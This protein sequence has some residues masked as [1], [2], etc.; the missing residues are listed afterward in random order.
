[1]RQHFDEHT[2]NTMRKAEDPL[3][4]AVIAKY[5]P[6]E[7]SSLQEILSK[8]RINEDLQNAKEDQ[9]LR[10]IINQMQEDLSQANPYLLK[11][12]QFF[13]DHASDI[14]LLLGFLSLPYCYAAAKGAEMLVRS[15]RILN[16]PAKRLAETAHFVFDVFHQNAFKPKGN[17]LVVILK[18]RLMHAATRWYI[19]QG[20][21]DADYFGAPVNQEDMA[22]TNLSFSLMV[23]RGLRRMGKLISADEALSYIQYWN[24]V[25]KLMGLRE[26]LLPM[27]NKAAHLLEKNIRKRQFK[28]SEAGVRLTE[29][30]VSYY[31][32][33]AEGT[34]LEG[35]VDQML[36]FL[37]GEEVCDLLGIESDPT[38][39]TL[40]KPY[41]LIMKLQNQLVKKNDSYGEAWFNYRQQSKELSPD[42]SFSLP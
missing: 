9:V 24:L 42:A 31:H 21:W 32:Q 18:V 1:M 7:K 22:G 19:K 38:K 17:A 15:K 5:F 28:Q 26:E 23:I 14:M 29:S 8:L 39:A 2:L 3:A 36:V 13:N 37:L 6:K 40:F 12:K 33:A 34:P 35:K 16:E 25:G 4:D 27:D 10:Q 11:G 20:E 30:L 41:T